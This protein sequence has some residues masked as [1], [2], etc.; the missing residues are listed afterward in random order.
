V[1]VNQ[2]LTDDLFTPPGPGDK[3]TPKTKKKK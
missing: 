2:D 3:I 1:A